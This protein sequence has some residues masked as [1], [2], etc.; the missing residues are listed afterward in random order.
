MKPADGPLLFLGAGGMGMAP[1]AAWL[2]GSGYSITGYDDNLREPV[3]RYLAGAG[4]DLRDFL[5][6]EE[7]GGFAAVVYSSAV[8]AGHPLLEAARVRGAPCLRRGEMLARVASGHK[9]LAVAGSHGK[10]TTSGLLAHLLERRGFAVNRI[11][12]GFPAGTAPA[13]HAVADSDWL[14]A[15][16][17]ESDGTIEGFSPEVLLLLNADW[18]HADRYRDER[19]AVEAFAALAGRTSATL[20]LPRG[21]AGTEA[22]AGRSGAR[23]LARFGPPG[24][25]SGGWNG[26]AALA[27]A[28]VLGAGGDASDLADFGGMRRREQVLAEG[29]GLAVVEDYAHHPTEIRMVLGRLRRR[30]PDRPVEVVFQPHRYSRTRQFKE[31]FREALAEADGLHLLPVYGAY[32]EP[33][34]GGATE[35]LR[36]RFVGAAPEVL[37]LA[38]GGVRRLAE[39]LPDGPRVLAFLGAGDVDV[40]ARL[41]LAARR[42]GE[43]APALWSDFMRDRVSPDCVLRTDEPLAS[44]T[45]LRVGGAARF[46]AEP[47]NLCDLRA[48]LE[49]ARL[50]GL[51]V[52]CLGRGS[53][54]LVAEGGFD[55]LV[56]RFGAGVWREIRELPGG[57]LWA[58]AGARLKQICARAAAAELSGFEFLEG[59]PGALGGALRMNAG[60]MG[61]WAFDLVERVHLIDDGGRLRDLPRSAFHFGYRQVEEISRGIAL[62]AVLKS[63]G[64]E[65]VGSIR[66]RM[67]TYSTLRKASQP[68]QPSAGCIFKN[69][70]GGHAGKLIDETGLKGL[71]VGGAEVSPL[72]ANFIVNRG[73]ATAG[74]VLELIGAVRERV[75][76]RT[77]VVLEPEVLLVGAD[78]KDVLPDVRTAAGG[79]ARHG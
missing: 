26:C 67:D 69:P 16:I 2:A 71:R 23:E 44:K 8:P 56:V 63:P 43:E 50:F 72:H 58:A 73:G 9:L 78:W 1:L 37:P 53:N 35:D 45:T 41:F 10:T 28:G 29:A 18:D 52:F 11:L 66:E 70:E 48:L 51:P 31:A 49:A 15:E 39:S 46:Y 20:L 14:L 36:A 22:V 21:L 60:A 12:G 59:I 34:E 32:E 3:R 30:F 62:G 40:F 47:H 64:T 42:C 24:D 55:G 13:P 19:S 7:C 6:A 33:L 61:S 54:L 38:L 76:A 74:D 77:G 17:D 65:A 27:A 57:R 5:L 4:V 68:R 25:E 79:G 75:A